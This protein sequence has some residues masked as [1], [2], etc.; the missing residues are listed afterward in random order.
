[1][2]ERLIWDDTPPPLQNPAPRGSAAKGLWGL[3]LHHLEE[4]TFPCVCTNV[5]RVPAC[6]SHLSRQSPPGRLVSPQSLLCHSPEPRRDVSPLSQS[7]CL[8]FCSTR[9]GTDALFLPKDRLWYPKNES[10]LRFGSELNS[11]ELGEKQQGWAPGALRLE[12]KNS[13]HCRKIKAFS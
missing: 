3:A 9:N 1:M 5:V 2:P 4:M 7:L 10:F 8:C 13:I 6:V 11:L 12:F